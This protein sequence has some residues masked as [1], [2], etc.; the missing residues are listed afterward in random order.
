M[1]AEEAKR[2]I[3]SSQPMAAALSSRRLGRQTVYLPLKNDRNRSLMAA[4]LL[5]DGRYTA[6][7]GK[8][9]CCWSSM[10]NVLLYSS[11][12]SL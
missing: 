7:S 9:I 12:V 1:S 2:A 11:L 6:D 8:G 5:S 10:S 3:L 4:T